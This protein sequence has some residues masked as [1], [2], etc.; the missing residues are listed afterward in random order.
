MGRG[1]AAVIV[2]HEISLTEYVDTGRAQ[3]R[4]RVRPVAVRAIAG[5]RARRAI[6]RI[7]A[8]VQQLDECQRTGQQ[9]ELGFPVR[10]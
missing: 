5:T 4:T 3:L 1:A 8:L 6:D 7:N 2:R 9:L 10:A